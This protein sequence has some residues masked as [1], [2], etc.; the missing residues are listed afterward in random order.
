MSGVFGVGRPAG[1]QG[2]GRLRRSGGP[3][4]FG[5]MVEGQSV[6][7]AETGETTAA[8]PT[9]GVDASLLAI[10]ERS[11]DAERDGR[12]RR[13]AEDMIEQLREMQAAMLGGRM[14]PTRLQGLASLAEDADTA[15]DP[16]LA[17]VVQ[18]VAARAKVELARMEVISLRRGNAWTTGRR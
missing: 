4:G 13:R 6:S 7:A 9:G 2:T 11:R 8:A 5:K 18:A 12:A 10:Q 16:G 15:A 17:E 1:P 3:A 14:D